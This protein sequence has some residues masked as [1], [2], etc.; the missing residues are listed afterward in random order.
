MPSNAHPARLRTRG[1]ANFEVHHSGSFLEAGKRL[2]LSTSTVAR[3]LTLME[4][5]LGRTLIH[6]TAKGT[7]VDISAGEL[8]LLAE[9]F[10]R[11]LA[12]RARDEKKSSAFAGVVRVSAPDG[13]ADAVTEAAC[14]FRAKHP[15]T[16]IE[17]IVEQRFVDL[18][19]READLGIRGGKSSSPTLIERPLITF[20]S[21][22]YA[23]KAYLDR[24]LPSR[25]LA[26]VDY[27]KHDFLVDESGA[28]GNGWSAWLV[29]LGATRFPFRSNS[30]SCRLIAGKHGEGI[31][32]MARG[33]E[34]MHPELQRIEVES[35][36]PALP[37]YVTMHR[38]LRRVP[39]MK[40]VADAIIEVFAEYDAS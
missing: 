18:S 40:G 12:T 23:S 36:L 26:D 33:M 28:K 39:R 30:F 35:P 10:E 21:A 3:R 16:I 37:F 7:T 34:R 19:A 22:L 14:R 27:P 13:M 38:D 6:R 11:A 31:V 32:A 17:V 9:D 24:A 2:G 1:F 4:R 5:H 8:L 20:Q 29:K 15:E 25:Y